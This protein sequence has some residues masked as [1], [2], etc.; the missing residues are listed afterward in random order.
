MFILGYF[1]FLF[2]FNKF[3]FCIFRIKYC[4]IETEI[5]TLSYYEYYDLFCKNFWL[6]S[7][8]CPRGELS[9]EGGFFWGKLEGVLSFWSENYSGWISS[10]FQFSIKMF[11][12]YFDSYYLNEFSLNTFYFI[13]VRIRFLKYIISWK[14]MFFL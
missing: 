13:E 14:E 6:K 4:Q 8:D 2:H 7:I 10:I 5:E 12:Q 11:S 1:G 3:F 9:L